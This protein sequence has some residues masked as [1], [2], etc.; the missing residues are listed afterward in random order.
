[1][2]KEKLIAIKASTKVP[3][4]LVV[5]DLM[6]DHYIKGKA[7]RLSPEAPV[8]VVNLRSEYSTLGGAGN[9]IQNLLGLQASVIVG[10][11]IGD[12]FGGQQLVDI[13]AETPVN[14]SSI[15]KDKNRATTLKTRIFVDGHH[16][17]RVDRENTDH[18]PSH[19]EEEL[20]ASITPLI[21]QADI[22][23]LSDYNKGLLSPSLTRRVIAEARK[24]G[25]KVMVDPKGNNFNKY[26]GANIIK[27]NKHELAIAAKMDEIKDFEDLQNAARIILET[28][29]VEQLVVTLSEEGIMIFDSNGH[30]ALPV[31]ATDVFD[32]TGAGDTVLATIAYFL[33]HGFLLSEACEL[34][35]HAAAIVIRQIGSATT[36]VDEIIEEIELEQKRIQFL[37]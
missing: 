2:L 12:D 33:S 17:A 28:T 29:E 4:I 1:M 15:V 32:V 22:V 23:V 25:K 16:L 34:A 26:Q 36:T 3:T 30:T 20:L 13:L 24:A 10:G 18:L 6:V 5:G 27:P 35:N 8:P 7:T 11:V 31:K 37:N 21:D 9:V 14:M 19:L